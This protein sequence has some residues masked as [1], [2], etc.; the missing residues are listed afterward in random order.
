MPAV[1]LGLELYL[2]YLSENTTK[3]CDIIKP[4]LTVKKAYRLNQGFSNW[5]SRHTD[6]S[7]AVAGCVARYL[8]IHKAFH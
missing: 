5:V 3:A 1:G 8:T 7:W 4:Y 6:M 2:V